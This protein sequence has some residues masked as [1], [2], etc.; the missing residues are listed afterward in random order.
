ML[1]TIKK[2]Q[3]LKIIKVFKKYLMSGTIKEILVVKRE[4]TDTITL[5]ICGVV[6]NMKC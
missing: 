1:E 4:L 3:Q 5:N 2:N 6:I